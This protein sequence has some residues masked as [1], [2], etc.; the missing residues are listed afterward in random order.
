MKQ[1]FVFLLDNKIG[2]FFCSLREDAQN[3]KWLADSFGRGDTIMW[4]YNIEEKFRIKFQ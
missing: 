1:D 4:Y 2:T 3:V